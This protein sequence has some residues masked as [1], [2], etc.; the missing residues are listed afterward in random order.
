MKKFPK[1][2]ATCALASTLAFGAI[3]CSD[4]NADLKNMISDLQN[5]I[6]IL[7]T[8][9]NDMKEPVQDPTVLAPNYGK[10]AYEKLQ[11]IDKTVNERDCM[12]G[13]DYGLAQKYIT[14][15]LMEAGYKQEDIVKQPFTMTKYVAKDKVSSLAPSYATDGKFYKR[16][17]RNYTE[18]TEEDYTHVSATLNLN[19]IVVK[20]PGKTNKQI[21]V[22]GHFDGNGSGDNGAAI[23][24]MLTTAE[25]LINI[26]TEYTITFVFYDAEEY[27][28]HGSKAYVNA[29][30][31]EEIDNTLYV[32]NIDSIVCGDY[33]YLYGGVQDNATKTVKQT[34]AYDN[35]MEV[36]QDLGLEFKSN[37]WT[38]DNMAPENYDPDFPDYASPS[39]GDWSD[40]APFAQKGI[41]Y[42]YFE[43]TNWE[44]PDYTGYGETYLVGM[45]MNTDNDY[46]AYIENYFP[47]RPLDHLTQFSTLLN[48]LLQQSDYNA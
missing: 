35:A 34:E 4:Q 2:L 38:W 3:G 37:P 36:A 47:T 46:L 28:M 15:T 6:S 14:W 24:L 1:I 22:G 17:G 19:N 20:K 45:I 31:Q 21:I 23:A 8:Q 30:T 33:C 12:Y 13:K 16:S 42:L 44:I 5:E 25:K 11:Y 9:I 40:H 29:M 10:E 7:Q 43:A 41:T 48:A 39:T 27:G 18:S 26:E 32:I